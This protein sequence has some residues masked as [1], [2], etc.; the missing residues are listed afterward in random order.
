MSDAYGYADALEAV[1]GELDQTF[2]WNAVEYDCVYG[3]R[4][5]NKTLE[6]GGYALDADLV[7]VVRTV[8]FESTQPAAQD[9]VTV[10][11]RT[12]R[13]DSVQH[14]PSGTFLVLACK[15]NNKGA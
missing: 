11:T 9:T 5:E 15:D 2:T 8:H 1:E 4:T 3:D 6:F 13:I 14:D 7:I 12:L 10:G